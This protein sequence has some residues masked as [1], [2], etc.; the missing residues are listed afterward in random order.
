MSMILQVWALLQNLVWLTISLYLVVWFFSAPL[1]RTESFWHGRCAVQ[2]CRPQLA[3]LLRLLQMPSKLVSHSPSFSPQQLPDVLII[4]RSKQWARTE[5]TLMAGGRAAGV[6]VQKSRRRDGADS[7]VGWLSNLC[8]DHYFFPSLF[9]RTTGSVSIQ[10]WF[11][12]QAIG[13]LPVTIRP[14][15]SFVYIQKGRETASP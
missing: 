6:Q 2:F 12:L 15:Y 10:D 13:Q 3:V 14:V 9:S 4:P 5:M 1:E 11:P 8:Q 7:M